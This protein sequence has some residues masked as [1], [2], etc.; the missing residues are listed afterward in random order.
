MRSFCL[1]PKKPVRLSLNEKSTWFARPMQYCVVLN[2]NVRKNLLI[3][4]PIWPFIVD[5]E[6][7]MVLRP[8]WPYIILSCKLPA[9]RGFIAS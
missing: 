2:A 6:A 5:L 4:K 7:P 8:P 3:C 1:K 9:H